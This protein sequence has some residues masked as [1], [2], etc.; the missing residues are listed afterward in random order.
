MLS[1]GVTAGLM[2]L[3]ARNKWF[4]GVLYAI[5]VCLVL[6]MAGK[7]IQERFFSVKKYQEDNSANSRLTSWKIGLRIAAENPVFG[8][9]VRNSPLL[10]YSYGADIEGRSI[11]SQYLQTAADSGV[12]ALLLY[13][14]LLGSVLVGLQQVRRHLLA[15]GGL[16][17]RPEQ[18]QPRADRKTEDQEPDRRQKPC[19]GHGDESR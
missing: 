1:L 8:V 14:G 18:R 5:G 15:N 11:H 17:C 2:F 3:R 13:L 16:P 12:P 19:K 9:G 10:T 6:V 7:E 4:V